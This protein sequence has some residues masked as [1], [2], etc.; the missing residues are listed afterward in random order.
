VHT[1]LGAG[2]ALLAV[3]FLITSAAAFWMAG[4]F[5]R[6]HRRAN[7]PRQP[8][9][10]AQTGRVRVRGR[11]TGAEP[12]LSP[13]SRTPCYYYWIDV[14]TWAPLPGSQW[15]WLSIHNDTGSRPFFLDDGTGRIAVN[16]DNAESDFD[17]VLQAQVAPDG[18][19][20]IFVDADRAPY[21]PTPRDF[22][23]YL[24]TNPPRKGEAVSW[25]AGT[26]EPASPGMGDALRPEPRPNWAT[27]VT[28]P[29]K[30]HLG[31]RFTERCLVADQEVEVLGSIVVDPL[32]GRTLAKASGDAVFYLTSKTTNVEKTTLVLRAAVALAVGVIFGVLGLMGAIAAVAAAAAG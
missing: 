30:A 5:W 22:Y 31:C 3:T 15:D 12:M 1:I 28:D 21:R 20:R 13:L 29:A 25:M 6:R 19:G 7:A 16:P 9:G 24:E 18:T 17:P 27:A 2:A 8:I 4:H 14:K 32:T 11:A 26:P 23:S 10:E